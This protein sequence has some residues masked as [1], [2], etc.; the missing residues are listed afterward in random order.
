MADQEAARGQRGWRGRRGTTGRVGEV[1]EPGPPGPPGPPASLP[2]ALGVVA[3]NLAKLNA[4]LTAQTKAS[5]RGRW[6]A[7]VAVFVLFV[8]GVSMTTS[9]VTVRAQNETLQEQG[10][11]IKRQAEI[12]LTE[13]LR[14][15]L[16]VLEH[17]ERKELCV[18]RPLNDVIENRINTRTDK[19]IEL[20]DPEDNLED[21]Q[22]R[23]A[24]LKRLIAER[25]AKGLVP[26]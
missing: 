17:R 2:E 13:S 20:C 11:E 4:T 10:T 9:L 15:E 22:V 19:K 24:E 14:R 23:I 12:E 5:R 7:G 6:L 26:R 1:G 25:E 8:V 21:L 18:V 16:D 3:D